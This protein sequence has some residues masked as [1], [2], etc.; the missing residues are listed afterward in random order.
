[1]KLRRTRA[2]FLVSDA[3]WQDV[4]SLVPIAI[5][6]EGWLPVLIYHQEGNTIDMDAPLH[7]LRSYF[8]KEGNALSNA[9]VVHIGVPS[10]Q[11]QRTLVSLL[12][13]QCRIAWDRFRQVAHIW[14]LQSYYT[15]IDTC[16]VV[17]RDDYPGGLAAA[18]FAA[19]LGAHLCFLDA[20]TLEAY[21]QEA[22]L[23][24]SLKR[25]YLVGALPK[26]V[27][28][29]FA[30]NSGQWQIHEVS[31]GDIQRMYLERVQTDKVI[32]VN[33]RDL[34][35]YYEEPNPALLEQT[36]GEM[37]Y[38]YGKCSLVAPFLAAAKE[39]VIIPIASRDIHEIN[40]QLDDAIAD[41]KLE[42]RYLTIVAS[43]EAIPMSEPE[44]G[45]N[46]LERVEVDGRRYGS[47][48]DW[49]DIDWAVGRIFGITVSDCSAYV[50]RVLFFEE[51]DRP[52]EPGALLVLLKVN[53]IRQYKDGSRGIRSVSSYRSLKKHLT[54][55]YWTPGVQAPFRCAWIVCG[56]RG[57]LG[58]RTR[59]RV[60][61]RYRQASLILY[62]GHASYDGFGTEPMSTATLAHAKAYLDGFPVIVGVGCLTGAYEWAKHS[63]PSAG[64]P[65][66]Q[67]RKLA[68]LFV[69]QNI[70]RGAMVQQCAVSTAYWHDELDDL[71]SALYVDGRSIGEAIRLAKNSERHLFNPDGLDN[72]TDYKFDGDPHYLLVGDPTF[73]PKDYMS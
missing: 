33:P 68:H 71:L 13:A 11:V 47:R 2:V 64:L 32:L 53:K 69:A 50:A 18:P 20:E 37:R 39:E 27:S 65:D 55:H 26:Q 54:K 60:E 29:F 24:G 28:S 36:Q 62:S 17:A 12:A 48:P 22:M 1:M 8:R 40:K 23:L 7:F 38:L 25:V 70:R 43:P 5:R 51:L 6:S 67:K 9:A 21:R 45:N 15:D 31:A 41:L 56:R 49:R 30:A 66:D 57:S 46:Q 19:S 73:V 10:S 44:R 42:P 59:K 58:K 34:E 72:F 61:R 3:C 63:Q 35:L 52:Q 14:R 4:L 16:V